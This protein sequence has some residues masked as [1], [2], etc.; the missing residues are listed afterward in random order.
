MARPVELSSGPV[1]QAET[2]RNL[3]TAASSHLVAAP[4][5]TPS[6]VARAESHSAQ[7]ADGAQPTSGAFAPFQ[8][9]A[10]DDNPRSFGNQD[11]TASFASTSA[12]SSEPLARLNPVTEERRSR[13]LGTSLPISNKNLDSAPNSER[14]VSRMS[15]DRLYESISRYGVGGDRFMIKF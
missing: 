13:L 3:I 15:E 11:F 1:A 12:A 5:L 9:S 2:P 14:L 6:T 7:V 10:V 8:P 4:A